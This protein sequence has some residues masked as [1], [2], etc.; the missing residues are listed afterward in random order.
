V[1]DRLRPSSVHR[2]ELPGGKS[3]AI[4]GE[5][6]VILHYPCCGFASFWNR[7]ITLEHVYAGGRE[8][9]WGKE[10]IILSP[11]H[12]DARDVVRRRDVVAARA[13]Y[14]RRYVISDDACINALLNN[15]VCCRILEPARLLNAVD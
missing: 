5:S 13:F 12:P 4:A 8:T 7:F 14:R 2:F 11:F 15:D 9:W 6:P 10:A 3:A 1:Q